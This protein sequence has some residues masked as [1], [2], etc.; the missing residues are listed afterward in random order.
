MKNI[1]HPYVGRSELM[2]WF[3]PYPR[4]KFKNI[5]FPNVFSIFIK[6]N[7]RGPKMGGW[8]NLLSPLYLNASRQK[9]RQKCLRQIFSA[10]I[11]KKMVQIHTIFFVLLDWK[12]LLYW[13]FV[14]DL[15]LLLLCQYWLIRFVFS[16][17]W[18]DF[19]FLN[20]YSFLNKN[21]A[22]DFILFCFSFDVIQKC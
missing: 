17:N 21:N 11:E 12:L 3:W 2:N 5:D 9:D 4:G 18:L 15:F 22:L 10:K 6:N 8:P 1:L 13:L 19:G 14:F 20:L 16:I 7:L